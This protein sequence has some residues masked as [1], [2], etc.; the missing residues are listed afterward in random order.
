MVLQPVT[1][2]K[3]LLHFQRSIEEIA[4]DAKEIMKTGL[5][6]LAL[7]L[8]YTHLKYITWP[9]LYYFNSSTIVLSNS[10]QNL[11][12]NH[13]IKI[14]MCNKLRQ[15]IDPGLENLQRLQLQLSQCSLSL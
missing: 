6:Y 3:K 1:K 5:F 12:N 15:L 2:R 13:T 8:R 4:G 7:I 10:L 14:K 11:C 9:C